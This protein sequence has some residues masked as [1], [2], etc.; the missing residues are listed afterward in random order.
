MPVVVIAVPDKF[1]SEQ[2]LARRARSHRP[3]NET[4]AV[5]VA[6]QVLREGHSKGPRW[7]L[8]NFPPLQRQELAQRDQTPARF[9]M[10]KIHS[11]EE[12]DYRTIRGR[13][14]NKYQIN[15]ER[16]SR[17]FRS[18][19]RGGRSKL[20]QFKLD[21]TPCDESWPW[22]SGRLRVSSDLGK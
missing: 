14:K 17:E 5:P 10:V 7:F 11:E 16:R 6:T 3:I 19:R 22:S 9:A 12:E 21:F 13:G 18:S 8:G 2:I 4:R 1:Q 15:W 20:D